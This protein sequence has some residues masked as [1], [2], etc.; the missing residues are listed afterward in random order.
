M[1]AEFVPDILKADV[2]AGISS[3]YIEAPAMHI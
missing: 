2:V 3:M 1:V